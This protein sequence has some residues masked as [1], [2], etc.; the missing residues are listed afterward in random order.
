[1]FKFE[2]DEEPQALGLIELV[3]LLCCD[4]FRLL[5]FLVLNLA[6]TFHIERFSIVLQVLKLKLI[7]SDDELRYPSWSDLVKRRALL[8]RSITLGRKGSER[9]RAEQSMTVRN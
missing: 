4:F 3:L 6:P 9:R 8:S 1:M 2:G 7:L 5:P